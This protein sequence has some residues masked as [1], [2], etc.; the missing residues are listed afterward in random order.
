MGQEQASLIKVE[1]ENTLKKGAI[2]QKEYQAGEFL[3][4]FF[5]FGK[6][7]WGKPV[8]GELKIPKLVHSIPVCQNG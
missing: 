3:R 5:L 6:N 4:N 2:Q 1:I 8:R 7:R